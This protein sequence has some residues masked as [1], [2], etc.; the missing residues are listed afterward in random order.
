VTDGDV[1]RVRAFYRAAEQN[2]VD[3]VLELLHPDVMWEAPE[4]LPYGGLHQGH[5]GWREYRKGIQENFEPGYK[6]DIRHTFKCAGQVLI[7]GRLDGTA[8]K[9]GLAFESPFLHVWTVNDEGRVVA[10]HYHV[11]T[12]ALLAAF[13]GEDGHDGDGQAMEVVRGV[14]DA[15]RRGDRDAVTALLD[16]AVE[17]EIPEELP[18]GGSFKGPDGVMRSRAIANEHFVPG[19]K[20]TPEH[21]FPCGDRIVGMG[22]MEAVVAASEEH[23]EVPFAHVWKVEGDKVVARRQYTDTGRI[24]RALLS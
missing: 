14:Y 1:A 24:L 8:K 19:Q 6:F 21:V 23:I 9:T 16:P 22:K 20:F 11:N 12:S 3:Q 10:R 2:D 17:W 4:P 7:L 5:D 13:T 15:T 18:Y